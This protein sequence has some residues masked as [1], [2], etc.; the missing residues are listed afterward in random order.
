MSTGVKVEAV[1]KAA[2]KGPRLAPWSYTRASN[3]DIAARLILS[4][5]TVKGHVSN[6]LG[7]L[8][9]ADRTQA[10]VYAWREGIVRKEEH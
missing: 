8:Q 6:N 9:F 10:A 5:K 1:W 4:E 7:R 2:R 3:S